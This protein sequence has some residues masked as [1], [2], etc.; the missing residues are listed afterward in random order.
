MKRGETLRIGLWDQS[1][2]NKK[3]HSVASE[4][5]HACADSR[6]NGRA[7]GPLHLARAAIRVILRKISSR[8]TPVATHQLDSSGLQQ[9]YYR[10]TRLEAE[11]FSAAKIPGLVSGAPSANR[12][13]G[14]T[15][16]GWRHRV[17]RRRFLDRVPR[18][19]EHCPQNSHRQLGTGLG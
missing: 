16:L 1:V 12:S 13:S 15:D 11:D 5:R 8:L 2:C 7:R 18:R 17:L 9:R 19:N 3:G 6:E 14:D 4:N 10:F